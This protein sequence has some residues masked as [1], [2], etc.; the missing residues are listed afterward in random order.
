MT[1]T[2]IDPAITSLLV[3]ALAAIFAW[4]AAT[5]LADVEMFAGAVATYRL[6]PRAL[7]KVLA[8]SVPLCEGACAVGLFFSATRARAAVGL[9]LL[10]CV[11]TGAIAINLLRGRTHIDCGCFGAALRQELSAWLLARNGV[12]ILLAALVAAPAGTRAME[13]MDYVTTGVGAAT[14]VMLYASAN[15]ALANAPRTRALEAL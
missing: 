8:W 14:M 10:L 15:Y 7:E 4:S 6:I 5:K 9:V 11:F 1:T 13:R 3:I 12:L 2:A